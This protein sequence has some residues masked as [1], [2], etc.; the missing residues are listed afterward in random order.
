MAIKRFKT[1][2]ALENI[3]ANLFL[4]I[5]IEFESLLKLTSEEENIVQLNRR[6][7]QKQ[8]SGPKKKKKTFP[9]FLNIF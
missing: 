7:P 5:S 1:I 8:N 3:F 9:I 6:L 4:E 2:F